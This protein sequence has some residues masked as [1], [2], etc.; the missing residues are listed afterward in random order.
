MKRLFKNV[1]IFLIVCTVFLEV[2]AVNATK[3]L[4]S[5]FVRETTI[6]GLVPIDSNEIVVEQAT[7]DLDFLKENPLD[8]IRNIENKAMLTMTYDLKNEGS[9]QK[10]QFFLPLLDKIEYMNQG[11]KL[12]VDGKTVEPKL[13]IS[14]V[15]HFDDYDTYTKMMEQD[16]VE[17][18][19]ET[20]LVDYQFEHDV[21]GYEY[22]IKIP[23]TENSNYY[24]NTSFILKD[25]KHGTVLMDFPLYSKKGSDIQTATRMY[26]SEEETVFFASH[27]M[28][29]E[30][31]CAEYKREN[32]TYIGTGKT[33]EDPTFT[34]KAV[35]LSDYIRERVLGPHQFADAPMNYITYLLD[36]YLSE[37]SDIYALRSYQIL[38][39]V[40]REY[41]EMALW[42][43]VEFSKPQIQVVLELP[44]PIHSS[45]KEFT[46][47]FV[48][49]PVQRMK[50]VKNFDVN[51]KTNEKLISSSQSYRKKDST[52]KWDIDA[53]RTLQ[54]V[55]KNSSYTNS[56]DAL[57]AILMLIG[58]ILYFFSIFIGRRPSPLLGLTSLVILVII[59]L[60]VYI[61]R[62]KR[63]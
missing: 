9:S 4:P 35:K 1:L 26:E 2:G 44:I 27:E 6:A 30:F 17:A 28:E 42:F 45:D 40:F 46:L 38:D 32:G 31:E 39:K 25:V 36:Q 54:V 47:E 15:L 56:R 48:P 18:Y 20:M 16:F 13:Y 52:F 8:V 57:I 22:T 23:K 34:K 49:N 51:I 63:K 5:S 59:L 61:S 58:A 43:E 24:I 21:E 53:T 33:V 60:Y 55:F 29:F 3:P 62:K 14:P 10:V 12:L 11:V 19:W 7:F 37:E 50:D 41:Y